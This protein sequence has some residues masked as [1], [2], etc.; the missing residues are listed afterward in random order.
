MTP[1]I[2]AKDGK[3]VMVVG[4]PGG[5][6]IINTVFQTLLNVLVHKHDIQRAVSAPRMHHQWM[7]DEIRCESNGLNPD[8]LSMLKKMGHSTSIVNPWGSCH[9][10][11]VDSKSGERRVGCD[12]RIS[13]AGSA[14]Y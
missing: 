7:P 12:P 2:V 6:T 13:T 11:F 9:A 3:L 14:G 5:P 4:S 8:T 1:T 10:I